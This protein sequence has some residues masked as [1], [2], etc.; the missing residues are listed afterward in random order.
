MCCE[1]AA[2]LVITYK[3]K[4]KIP[5]DACDDEEE[6]FFNMREQVFSILQDRDW[7]MAER[8]E[9]LMLFYDLAI[10][11]KD[12]VKIFQSLER[13][14]EGWSEKIQLLN[15]KEQSLTGGWDSAFE[16]IMV[17]FVYRHLP[18]GM[19]DG[20]IKERLLF[21][22][23]STNIIRKLFSMGEQTEENLVEICRMYS[24]EIEYSEENIEKLLDELEE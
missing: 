18:E 7:T 10:P 16:Q 4:V 13:L 3:E 15:K 24:S 17:Y 23:L 14:D 5:I 21:A 2:R 19:Y 20:R 6:V 9:N 11:D 22:T 12:W 1:E 8:L